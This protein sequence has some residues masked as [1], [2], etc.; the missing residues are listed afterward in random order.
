MQLTPKLLAYLHRIFVVEA[1]QFLALRL[2]HRDGMTWKVADARL[3]TTVPGHPE[4]GLDVDLS[5]YT[6][7]SLISYLAA[8]PGYIIQYGDQSELAALS[9]RVLIDG[10]NDVARSNGDHLYGYTNIL[11]SYMEAMAVE[12]QEA[13]RQIV[14]ALKQLNTKTAQGEWLDLLGSYYAVPRIQGELDASYGPRIIAEVLR[15]RANNVAMEEAIKV[16]TGQDAKVTDV[17]L[18]GETFPLYDGAITHNGTWNYNASAIPIYGLFDVEY[19]YDFEGGADITAF[20]QI[21]REL[22]GRLRDAGTHLRSLLLRGS[23]MSDTFTPPTDGGPIDWSIQATLE[24]TLDEPDDPDFAMQATLAA[25]QDTL[26]EPADEAELSIAYAYS[27]NGLRTHN[28]IITHAG[29]QT[30]AESL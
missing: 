22:I 12:L 15:P 24:D 19:G 25:M 16:F 28:G 26:A 5:Q 30:L 17:T 7:A 23:D 18:Y 9:A 2:T 14:E 6:V 21:V 27:Y 1:D 10:Q 20:Q 4:A 3:T 13:R 8:Q 29:G 11:W